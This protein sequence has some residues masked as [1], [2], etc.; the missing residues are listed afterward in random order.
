MELK[1]I[2][3]ISGKGGLFKVLKP[4]RTG[5]ILEAIDETRSKF[6]AG[7]SQRVSLLKEISIYTTSK[8][9][10]FPLEDLLDKLYKEYGDTLP[11]TG[12]SDNRDLYAFLGKSIPDYD[13]S[14]VYPSDIK[15][16]IS[17]YN[18]LAKFAPEVLQKSTASASVTETAAMTEEVPAKTEVKKKAAKK[19]LAEAEQDTSATPSGS[20]KTGTKKSSAK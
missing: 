4:T 7:A 8:E 14:K 18:I 3:S 20:K 12:K 6:I 17:W 5:V 19:D 16:L 11:V 13:Q 1:D 9:G 2:A 15:K 10:S